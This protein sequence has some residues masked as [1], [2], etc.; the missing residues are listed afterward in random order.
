MT[1]L[2]PLFDVKIIKN[3]FKIGNHGGSSEG[4]ILSAFVFLTPG[5]EGT[6]GEMIKK[7]GERQIVNQVDLVPTL[8][9]LFGL[10]IPKNN[11]GEVIPNLF[12]SCKGSLI[13]C[14]R[15]RL[16]LIQQILQ[17]LF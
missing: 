9:L 4:E 3:Y 11:K 17:S 2:H 10:P 8:S 6:S 14:L 16:P 1:F 15:R 13:E 7:G 5:K 12:T